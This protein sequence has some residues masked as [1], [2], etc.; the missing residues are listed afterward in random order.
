[1]KMRKKYNLFLSKFR[2][3]QQILLVFFV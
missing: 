3:A 2:I 1:M